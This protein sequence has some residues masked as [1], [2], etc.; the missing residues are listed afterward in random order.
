MF[1]YIVVKKI[2]DKNPISV[3]LHF[4]PF[5]N[6]NCKYCFAHFRDI[7]TS[8]T[9]NEWFDIIE[10]LA[11]NNFEKINFAGGE[12]T[13]CPFLDDLIIFA[14]ELGLTTSLISNGT[15][16]NQEFI[17]KIRD[18]IDWIG[19]SL[20]S[21]HENTQYRLGRGNGHYVNGIL[22]KSRLVKN[23]GINLK[24]NTVITKLN[25]NEDMNG[26]L[27]KINP[28]RWK[29]FQVLFIDNQN[30]EWRERLSITNS[31]F[32]FFLNQHKLMN[33]IPETNE[34]MI[35]SYIMVNPE[36]RFFQNSEMRYTY[37]KPILN[38]G[39]ENALNEIYYN[40]QKFLK[41]GGLYCWS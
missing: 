3:N 33:P 13:L 1:L 35:N 17:N 21:S 26:I 40:H 4:W 34:A 8:L 41:R 5:C 7:N 20:D 31:E 32:Q 29:A 23:A 19:L 37:S 38:V 22:E 6:M 24:I 27:G 10:E 18:S 30:T 9:K 12:P 16:I 36:G 15:G 25:Y 11:N 39:V 14:K 2:L 28:K